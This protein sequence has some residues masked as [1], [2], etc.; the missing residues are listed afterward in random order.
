MA[1][2]RSMAM[3]WLRTRVEHEDRHLRTM[4]LSLR[5][6]PLGAERQVAR[7]TDGTSPLQKRRNS[8]QLQTPAGCRLCKR[9][10]G[11]ES[12]VL[13]CPSFLCRAWPA[14]S[15]QP[16]SLKLSQPVQA[17][18]TQRH[19]RVR[20]LAPEPEGDGSGRQRCIA[21]LNHD[22]S[23][24]DAR[25]GFTDSERHQ[26]EAFYIHICTTDY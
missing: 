14:C 19:N 26:R 10:K 13:Y 2:V 9:Q 6:E 15:M 12:G 5:C 20:R 11:K 22:S 3:G 18:H 21:L 16:C 8:L 1:Q 7:R 24:C 4:A 17:V 25:I 23:L